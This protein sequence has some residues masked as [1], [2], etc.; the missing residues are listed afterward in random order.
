M[1][2]IQVPRKIAGNTDRRTAV[3]GFILALIAA[4]PMRAHHSFSSEYDMKKPITVK[5]TVT[6]VEWTNP[7]TWFYVEGKDENGEQAT[8]GFEG[9]APS[10]L[11]RRGVPRYTIKVGDVIT[12][13]GFRAKDGTNVASS[14]YAT[15]PDGKKFRTGV[16]GGPTDDEI[17]Q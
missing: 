5:G 14:A 7:H 15:R 6:K 2:S 17:P 12:M 3:C 13:E 10:V 16:V 9:A 1:R 4:V 8:W 11:T